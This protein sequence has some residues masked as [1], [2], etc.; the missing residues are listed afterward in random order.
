MFSLLNIVQDGFTQMSS[1]IEGSRGKQVAFH[2]VLD[3]VSPL[4]IRV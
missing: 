2:R 4:L 3:L 1:L